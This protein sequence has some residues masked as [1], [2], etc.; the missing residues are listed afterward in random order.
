MRVR[1]TVPHLKM[2]FVQAKKKKKF[3]YKKYNQQE[4]RIVDYFFLL[5]LLKVLNEKS[6]SLMSQKRSWIKRE[7]RDGDSCVKTRGQEE[8]PSL[9][10][11]LLQ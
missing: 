1:A 4:M 2:D 5:Y 7:D 3:I 6:L 8:S 10:F 11:I 9:L